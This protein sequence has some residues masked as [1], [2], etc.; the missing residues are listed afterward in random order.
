MSYAIAA[1]AIL[2]LACVYLGVRLDR[3]TK[4][5]NR[6][7]QRVMRL[8]MKHGWHHKDKPD[9]VK[10]AADWMPDPDKP[11]FDLVRSPVLSTLFVVPE[12]YGREVAAAM[13][14]SERYGRTTA[15]I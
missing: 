1:I 6:A 5:R 10:G 2:A 4:D 7:Q 3:A 11:E 8:E 12:G 9:Y 15:S 13:N 14:L